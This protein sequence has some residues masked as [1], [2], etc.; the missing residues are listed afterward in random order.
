[1]I[2]LPDY[3]FPYIVESA[4]APMIPKHSWQFDAPLQDFMLKKIITLEE[5]TG[6]VVKVRINAFDFLIPTSWNIMIVD[7]EN[8]YV[9]VMPIIDAANNGFDAYLM[10]PS[11]SIFYKSKIEIL[12]FIQQ[13]VCAH[14]SIYKN[15]MMCH[16]VGPIKDPSLIYSCLIGP[17]DIYKHIIGCSPTELLF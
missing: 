4:I 9:D 11:S 1:M 6:P 8:L 12:D 14:P 13:D 2:I 10:C 7:D 5:T 3:G 16:P 17:Q 15:C